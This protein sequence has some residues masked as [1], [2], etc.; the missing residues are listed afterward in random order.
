M[1]LPRPFASQKKQGSVPHREPSRIESHPQPDELRFIGPAEESHLRERLREQ[2]RQQP[3]RPGGLCP[4]C[5]GHAFRRS[6]L[7]QNSPC[8]RCGKQPAAQA[9]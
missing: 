5:G 2:G 8:P 4:H 9:A 3:I 7:K 1:K 6:E